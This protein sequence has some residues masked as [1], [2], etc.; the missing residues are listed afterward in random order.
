MAGL[1]QV[2]WGQADGTFQA[3]EELTGTDGEPLE[4]SPGDDA[5]QN[6]G[7]SMETICTR[8]TAVD[9]DGDGDLDL[10]VG[11]FRG[12]FYLYLGEGSGKFQPQAQPILT[13]SGPLKIQGA[14]SDPFIV[15][16]DRDG[17]LDLMSGSSQ[18]GVQWAQNIAEPGE[19]PLLEAF[20]TVIPAGARVEFGQ[21]LRAGDLVGPTSSTRIWIDDVNA[22]GKLDILVGDSVALISPKGEITDEEYN[23]RLKTWQKQLEEANEKMTV[24]RKQGS[25]SEEKPKEETSGWTGWLQSLLGT[26]EAKSESVQ[27]RERQRDLYEESSQFMSR[28][29]T[30]FVWL[31]LQK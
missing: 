4:I 12:S 1:F 24:L 17:D 19:P 28:E 15:D 2:L 11:N 26:G 18:G 10:V 30:G 20:E 5:A 8:P 9:W 23:M 21:L 22:D 29:S 6:G 27:A 13:G 7:V 16:W 25:P 14:H 3:V 31:Y